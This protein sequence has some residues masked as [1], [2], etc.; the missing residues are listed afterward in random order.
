MPASNGFV[1]GDVFAERF[2]IQGLLGTGGIHEVYL[3]QGLTLAIDQAIFDDNRPVKV[4]RPVALKLLKPRFR[5]HSLLPKALVW[6]YAILQRVNHAAIVKALQISS[7]Q[8]IPYLVLEYAVGK[9]VKAIIRQHHAM[10]VPFELVKPMIGPLADGLWQ[11]HQKGLVHADVKPANIIVDRNANPKWID[12]GIASCCSPSHDQER[13]DSDSV[14][15][16]MLERFYAITPGYVSPERYY[17]ADSSPLDDVFALG[18]TLYEM[19]SG[20]SPFGGLA[21]YQVL[22]KASKPKRLTQLSKKQWQVLRASLA[23]ER[24]DRLP[25]ITA[26]IDEF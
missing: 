9:S 8:N 21:P 15:I 10:G 7:Y 3:A 17:K 25:S 26:F 23:L 5:T 24:K 11:L 22:A 19:I 20:V 18:L 13:G 12:F 1:V 4:P 2:R 16:K 6:E 14:A